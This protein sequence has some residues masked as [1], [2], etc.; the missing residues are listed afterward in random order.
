MLYLPFTTAD[1]ESTLAAAPLF[2]TTP[3]TDGTVADGT[4]VDGK[5]ADGELFDGKLVGRAPTNVD[6]AVVPPADEVPLVVAT[7]M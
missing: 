5:L 1:P 2:D 4:L 3:L 6:L 7:V